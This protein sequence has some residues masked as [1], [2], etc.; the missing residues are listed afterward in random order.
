MLKTWT[1]KLKHIFYKALLEGCTPEKLTRSFCLGIYIS[2]SPFPGLHTVM[3][4]ASMYLFDVHLPTLFL[5]TSINNPWTMAPF[6]TT[7]Y[8]FGRWLLHSFLAIHPTWVITLPK[9]FGSGTIC[10]WSFLIGGNVLGV[11]CAMAL[12]PFASVIFKK[13][14]Q[15]RNRE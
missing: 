1:E 11:V 10:L 9:I 6:F 13:L 12:W 7:D 14:S 8:F 3:M 2:F 15:G 5:A 4:I